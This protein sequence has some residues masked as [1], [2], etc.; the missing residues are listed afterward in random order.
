MS[1]PT[2][3]PVGTRP[4]LALR[5][6][7]V[8]K[9]YGTGTGQVHALR[10]LSL[11]LPAGSFTAVM[12][13]SGSGKSTFLH[14]A[15]GL[16]SPT[17][18]SIVLGAHEITGL[19]PDP[20]T[21]FRRDRVGFVFQ[22]YNLLPQ[23]TVTQNITLPLLLA[24]RTAEPGH[25]RA[26]AA[27]VGLADM[28]DRLPGELS[29]GQAQRVAIARALITR[30]EVL[31]ADEPTGALDSQTGREVLDLLRRTATESGQTVVVVT[32]DAVVASV[33][34]RVLFLADG[35]FVGHLDG[36]DP[37]EIAAHMTRLAER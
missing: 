28:V 8:T 11:D 18:G 2:A 35:R 26:L 14:C 29:G 25:V 1:S 32:H 3:V 21:R 17:S 37:A 10:G 15:A 36:A 33:A 5:F 31:F 27:A 12:G 34:D 22:S 7:A 4:A 23:L 13:P 16:D 30:P 6:G 9:T 19:G 24:G 20:L